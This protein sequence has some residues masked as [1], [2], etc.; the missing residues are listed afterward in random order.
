[1]QINGKLFQNINFCDVFIL[2]ILIFEYKVV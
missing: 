1:M 2:I